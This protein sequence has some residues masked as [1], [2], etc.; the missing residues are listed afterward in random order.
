MDFF[1][2]FLA[3]YFL[4]IAFVYAVLHIYF[5]HEKKFNIRYLATIIGIPV[6]AWF[7]GRFI[8]N[9]VEHP[10]P[11]LAT[12][13]IVPDSL[14]SFPSGHATLMFALAATMYAYDKKAGLILF[15]LAVATGIAR[16]LAGVHYWYDIVGGAVLGYVVSL[17]VITVLKRTIIK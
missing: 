10:R 13:L 6:F 8:K 16:V 15:V 3:E 7:V 9:V 12:A 14:Y 5:L 1:I 11:D 4:Y 2:I 17:I